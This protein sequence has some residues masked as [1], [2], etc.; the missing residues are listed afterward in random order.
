[1]TLGIPEYL[2][3]GFENTLR[4]SNPVGLAITAGQAVMGQYPS[5]S[6]DGREIGAIVQDP[7]LGKTYYAGRNYGT[8]TPGSFLKIDPTRATQDP[9]EQ[10]IFRTIQEKL[11][12]EAQPEQKSSAG[13]SSTSSSSSSGTT[14]SAGTPPSPGRNPVSTE[15]TQQTDPQ[16]NRIFDELKKLT[17][18]E[19]RAKVTQQ[20]LEAE[21]KRALIT[22]ALS[23][24]QSR[25]STRRQV[26]LEN[27]KAWRDLEAA[28][29]EANSRQAAAL[30][31]AVAISMQPNVGLVEALNKSY[32]SAIGP[33]SNF[34]LKG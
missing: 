7:N 19:Y 3:K 17:D 11:R 22:N 20:D 12:S 10:A 5:K 21:V 14:A 4:L 9:R 34:T 29:I 25:E 31:A 23:M 26:E 24:R 13:S 33:Y 28:R 2:L 32:A 6:D 1:M 30:G 27:I 8:Q 15:I 18:P 16:L